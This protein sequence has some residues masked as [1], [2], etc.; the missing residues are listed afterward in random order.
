MLV[1]GLGETELSEAG[2]LLLPTKKATAR[3]PQG[4]GKSETPPASRQASAP[5]G[6]G[7]GSQPPD[8]PQDP[9]S[10]PS[11]TRGSTGK[12][13][14]QGR[15]ARNPEGA[16]AASPNRSTRRERDLPTAEIKR[17]RILSFLERGGA[18][19]EP[20]VPPPRLPS[21]VRAPEVGG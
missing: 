1:C 20:G 18:V 3:L 7:G 4:G 8:E 2:S 5:P 14:A 12:T 10:A 9:C 13:P 19:C 21:S 17:E 16:P 15:L 11:C 6:L